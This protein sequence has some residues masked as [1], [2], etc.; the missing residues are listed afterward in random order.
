MGICV[1]DSGQWH[2]SE[3]GWQSLSFSSPLSYDA[4][5]LGNAGCILI[6]TT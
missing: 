1:T 2:G 6:T 3:S 5:A 4:T